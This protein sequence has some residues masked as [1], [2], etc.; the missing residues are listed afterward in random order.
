MIWAA[1]N[2]IR[3]GE[4]MKKKIEPEQAYCECT[5]HATFQSDGGHFNF[6][7]NVTVRQ[8]LTCIV[9]PLMDARMGN[10][11]VRVQSGP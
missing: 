7:R 8:Y 3:G 4:K 10:F 5:V 2:G 6:G 11:H 9:P 1:N